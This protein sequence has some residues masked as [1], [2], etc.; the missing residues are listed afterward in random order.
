M[1][2]DSVSGNSETLRLPRAHIDRLV[3]LQYGK[4]DRDVGAS[5]VGAG[6]VF[7]ACGERHAENRKIVC[8]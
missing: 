3:L 1:Y 7:P 2:T 4:E 8:I 6:P 5:Q